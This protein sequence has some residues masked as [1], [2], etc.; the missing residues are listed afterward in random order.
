MEKFMNLNVEFPHINCNQEITNFING[1]NFI[2]V[3]AVFIVV[4]ALLKIIEKMEVA[5]GELNV[6]DDKG[7]RKNMLLVSFKLAA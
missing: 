7:N 1:I 2:N 3:S 5:L 4:K 6:K